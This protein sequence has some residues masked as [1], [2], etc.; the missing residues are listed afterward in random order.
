MCMW[1]IICVCVQEHVYAGTKESR[2]GKLGPLEMELNMIESHLSW[3]MG[4]KPW[5]PD[6]ATSI[7]N[8]WAF[9]SLQHISLSFWFMECF[10]FSLWNYEL[11]NDLLYL[12]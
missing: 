12:F 2:R 7:L 5:S 3:I 10:S 4:I 9:S 1:G 8:S 11:N 6:R